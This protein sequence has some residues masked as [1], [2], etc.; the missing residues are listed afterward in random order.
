MSTASM[1]G[2]IALLAAVRSPTPAPW[3]LDDPI[4]E[5][6]SRKSGSVPQV[7]PGNDPPPAIGAGST[8]AAAGDTL[9]GMTAARAFPRADLGETARGKPP[10]LS[11]RLVCAGWWCIFVAQAIRVAVT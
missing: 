10:F 6:R 7:A 5:A 2:R 8:S 11:A 1:V 9:P 4:T 3:S